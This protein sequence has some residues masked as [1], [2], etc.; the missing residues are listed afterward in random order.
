MQRGERSILG[1]R[2]W[3]PWTLSGQFRRP[4][5]CRLGEPARDS[6][7]RWEDRKNGFAPEG[8]AL[9]LD[10]FGA[11]RRLVE[12]SRSRVTRIDRQHTRNECRR[13]RRNGSVPERG[14]PE[15][16]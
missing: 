12:V 7:N 8:A 4:S 11:Q 9:P 5:Q 14:F 16:I 1:A 6:R 3:F 15:Q 2:S 10:L 13:E